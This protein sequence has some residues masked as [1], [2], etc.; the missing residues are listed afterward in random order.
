MKGILAYMSTP[1]SL[2]NRI[3]TAQSAN[4]ALCGD[5]LRNAGREVA[6]LALRGG[7]ELLA[8]DDAGERIIGA[9]LL[10]D[11]GVRA[12]D[13][14]RRLD[15]RSVLLVAGHV[16]GTTGVASKADLARSLG[17]AHVRAAFLSEEGVRIDGCDAVVPLT[18]RRHLIAL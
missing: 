18:S 2:L 11:D 7:D 6:A 12:V 14:S 1:V 4:S 3:L 15:N 13:T 9:A 17:A 10:A 16:A 8:V 5:D